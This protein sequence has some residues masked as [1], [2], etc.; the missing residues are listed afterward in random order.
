MAEKEGK[1]PVKKE[2]AA[3][4]AKEPEYTVQEIIDASEQ[5]LGVTKECASAALAPEKKTGALMTV[6]TAK[7]K[8]DRF[9]AKE[10]K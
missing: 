3:V 7:K 10:V 9:M 4:H 1:T 5:A 2:S 6:S 8:I